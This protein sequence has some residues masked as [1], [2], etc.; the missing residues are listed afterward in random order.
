MII[1]GSER[2]KQLNGGDVFYSDD[3][4]MSRVAYF[5]KLTNPV[6]AAN[7]NAALGRGYHP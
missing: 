7:A 4:T 1:K 2:F 6:G 5:M 3:V